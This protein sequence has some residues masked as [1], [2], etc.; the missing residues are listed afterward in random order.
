[1][2][3]VLMLVTLMFFSLMRAQA[4]E[5]IYTQNCAS[6]HGADGEGGIGRPALAGNPD[7]EDTQHVL[8]QILQG[9]DGMPA[10]VNQ[11]SNEQVAEVATYIRT[12]WE[13]NFGEVTV[14]QVEDV[15]GEQSSEVQATDLPVQ[16][17]QTQQNESQET[18]PQGEDS[19][20]SQAQAEE[21]DQ[22][23]SNR[24]GEQT[25]DIAAQQQLVADLRVTV[26]PEEAEFQISG[27]PGFEPQTLSGGSRML[28][29]LEP[30]GYKI[31]ATYNGQLLEQ[32]VNVSG[33]EVSAVTFNFTANASSNSNEA[34]DDPNDP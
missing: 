12:N 16:D 20:Q 29:G 18:T 13:N 8:G 25:N 32:V 28:S 11:L 5:Q 17:E 30:G 7:L 23:P 31:T 6:C 24:T 26:L 3:K 1:M 14:A 27:P 4:G 15:T 21:T 2:K 9:G 33:G 34:T 22:T 10:F 19:S